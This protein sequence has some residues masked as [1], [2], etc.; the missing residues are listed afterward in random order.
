MKNI[1]VAFIL[2]LSFF[3]FSSF[4]LE[5]KPQEVSLTVTDKGF[6]PNPLKVKAGVPV[7]LRI[8]RK[9]D[10]TCANDIMI[11]AKNIKVELPLNR[12]ILVKVSALEKGEIKFGCSMNM[13]ISAVMI[14]N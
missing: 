14:A 8:T 10:G 11:P 9:T 1:I 4:A 2:S 6:Q 5:V 13:M 7:N 3:S 12:E